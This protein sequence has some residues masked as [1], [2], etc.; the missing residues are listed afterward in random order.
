MIVLIILAHQLHEQVNRECCS[1]YYGVLV[2]TNK[3]DQKASFQALLNG[4]RAFSKELEKTPGP[5]FVGGAQLS[6]ADI[7][8]LPWAFRYTAS[9]SSAFLT[10]RRQREGAQRGGEEATGVTSS[11]TAPVMRVDRLGYGVGSSSKV[12]G[13]CV[14]LVQVLRV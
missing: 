8:I 7:S 3:E 5:T 10:L 9:M 4:L 12:T 1:P 6:A 11:Q 14:S 13:V 2:K